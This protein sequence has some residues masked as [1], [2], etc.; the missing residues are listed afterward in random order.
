M[1]GHEAPEWVAQ[2]AKLQRAWQ[3]LAP[4]WATR[5]AELQRAWQRLAHDFEPLSKA[6]ARGDV[7]NFFRNLQYQLR[8]MGWMLRHIEDAKHNP[9]HQSARFWLG[10]GHLTPKQ[11]A[12]LLPY[13]LMDIPDL[14]VPQRKGRPHRT[15]ASIMKMVEELDERIERT[16]ELPTTAA[17]RLLAEKGF[18][19]QDIKGRADYLVRARKNRA[20]KSR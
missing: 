9:S 12:V 11:I 10:V 17:K 6:I 1:A 4:E 20:L 2:T 16:G 13:V 15:A 14:R 19:G 18:R 5:I 7:R 3:R 8:W